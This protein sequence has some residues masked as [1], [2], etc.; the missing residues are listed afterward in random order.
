MLTELVLRVRHAIYRTFAEG[1]VPLSATLSTQLGIPTD[2]IRAAYERLHE[3]HAIVLN[4]HSREVWMALPFSA[5]PTP[6]RVEG[7]GRTWFANCAWDMFGIPALL[8]GEARCETTCQDCDGAIVYRVE[9]GRLLDAH[10]VV[11]FLVPAAR[12]W[13][14]IG[15]T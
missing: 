12:W 13:D 2:E 9:Q 1:G 4:P 14:D 7:M 15:Y 3:M 6:F 11:H 5:V 8:G 10:G